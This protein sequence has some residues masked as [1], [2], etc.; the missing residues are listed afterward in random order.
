MADVEVRVKTEI[1]EKSKRSFFEGME[2]GINKTFS[3]FKGAKGGAIGGIAVGT[4]IGSIISKPIMMIVDA[5]AD[6][7]MVVAVMKLLKLVMTVLL[8]PLVP[9]LKPALIGLSKLATA[10]LPVM[11]TL[12]NAIDSVF[13]AFKTGDFSALF[14]EIPMQIL[15]SIGQALGSLLSSGSAVGMIAGGIIGG[16]AFGPFGI[17]IGGAI[18]AAVGDL[19]GAPATIGAIVGGLI[20][21]LAGPWGIAIGGAIGAALGGLIGGS[22]SKSTKKTT[23]DNTKYIVENTQQQEIQTIATKDLTYTYSELNTTADETTNFLMQL[24]DSAYNT[25]YANDY[26]ALKAQNL[27]ITFDASGQLVSES[28]KKIAEDAKVV[29][30]KQAQLSKWTTE[31]FAAYSKAVKR[32]GV[33]SLGQGAPTSLA[34]SAGQYANYMKAGLISGYSIGGTGYGSMA[35]SSKTT[36]VSDAII[37]PNGEVIQTDPNDTLYAVK[38]GMKGGTNVTINIDSPTILDD[39]MLNKLVR[40]IDRKFQ[41]GTR[42]GNSY[43]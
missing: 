10:L 13:A 41:I 33:D 21:A 34:Q 35:S 5:L 16:I 17:L 1:D 9:I 36:K 22:G 15:K 8:L 11:T 20:G 18:G 43:A 3:N 30:E 38:G 32:S 4:A 37:R 7:P 23:M 25:T 2:A 29:A 6:F 40:E 42:R 19:L 26:A 31:A 14:S 28:A 39:S 24:G 27:G 12:S